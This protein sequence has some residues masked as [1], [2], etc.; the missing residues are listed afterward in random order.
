MES[1]KATALDQAQTTGNGSVFEPTII[2]FIFPRKTFGACL[3]L[4]TYHTK[5]MRISSQ[6]MLHKTFMMSQ[7][8]TVNKTK[9]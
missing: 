4:L 3:S 8:I 1:M 6:M 2:H 5:K 7:W 9:L